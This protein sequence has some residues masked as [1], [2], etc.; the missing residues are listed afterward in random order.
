MERQV[1]VHKRWLRHRAIFVT[2]SVWEGILVRNRGSKRV[3][4]GAHSW[5]GSDRVRGG[6]H[7]GK[8]WTCG[9]G[10]R[11]ANVHTTDSTII[12]PAVG[13]GGA[14]VWLLLYVGDDLAG[15]QSHLPGDKKNLMET[16]AEAL[17]RLNGEDTRKSNG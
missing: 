12:L 15:R 1:H 4:S 6:M 3:G 17:S 9:C 8:D 11:W 2:F 13:R 5:T 16:G 7:W 14:L 10:H